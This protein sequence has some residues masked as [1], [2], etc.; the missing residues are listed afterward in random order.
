MTTDKHPEAAGLS[1]L[2][3]GSGF[4]VSSLPLPKDHWLYTQ[5]CELWDKVH[6][7]PADT[8]LPILSHV[9]RAE[10]VTAVR[11][12]IRAATRQ[13]ADMNLNCDPDA[14]VQNVVYALC[15]AYGR[16]A[17]S[18]DP[19]PQPQEPTNTQEP[20]SFH[21]WWARIPAWAPEFEQHRPWVEHLCCSA[22]D[23]SISHK[24]NK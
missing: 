21:A 11:Y 12:A 14:V 23:A 24:E 20:E 3:D 16:A 1:E 9:L 5:R 18:A 6:D 7:R 15:G 2:P 8:P 22:W 4:S 10:V 19:A 13:D 17:L